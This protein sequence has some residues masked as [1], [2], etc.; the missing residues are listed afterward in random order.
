M[1]I[2]LCPKDWNRSSCCIRYEASI[3]CKRPKKVLIYV[4]HRSS[5]KLKR[6]DHVSQVILYEYDPACLVCKIYSELIDIPKSALAGVV[7]SVLPPIIAMVCLSNYYMAEIVRDCCS[8]LF[9]YLQELST[10]RIYRIRT[11]QL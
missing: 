9:C 11:L 10:L 1:H 5:A 3:I 7:A 4:R 6:R 8:N 2:H